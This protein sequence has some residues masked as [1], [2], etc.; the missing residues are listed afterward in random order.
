MLGKQQPVH[1]SPSAEHSIAKPRVLAATV[2]L[3]LS[4]KIAPRVSV[5]RQRGDSMQRQN[6]ILDQIPGIFSAL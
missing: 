6:V 1:A 3:S 5:P 2:S 4:L